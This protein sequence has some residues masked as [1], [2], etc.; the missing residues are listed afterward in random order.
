[1]LV[2]AVP[3]LMLAMVVLPYTLL[4]EVNAWYGSTLLWIAGTAVIIG[5]N[6][7]LSRSWKD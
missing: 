5:I 4:S 3:V 6:I 7:A 2:I 1:M